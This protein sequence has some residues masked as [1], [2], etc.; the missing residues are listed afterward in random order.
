MVPAANKAR[1][2]EAGRVGGM[3]VKACATLREALQYALGDG[4]LA[5]GGGAKRGYRRAA[6]A[7]TAGGGTSDGDA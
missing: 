2:A 3:V 4:S 1:A 5:A 6:A 7:A